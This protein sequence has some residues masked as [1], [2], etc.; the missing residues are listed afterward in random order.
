LKEKRVILACPFSL[1]LPSFL[2]E[3]IRNPDKT[4][5]QKTKEKR[6][7]KKKVE[8][9]GERESLVT[10]RESLISSPF[11]ISRNQ[12]KLFNFLCFREKRI[13]IVYDKVHG[14]LHI[15]RL[16]KTSHV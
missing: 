12:K 3:E 15:A 9:E 1:L 5:H 16:I 7:R 4:Q 11:F 14:T 2:V 13:V 6:G 8:E 10:N